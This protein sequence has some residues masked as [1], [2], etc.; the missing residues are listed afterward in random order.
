[1]S[2]LNIKQLQTDD[3]FVSCG[4]IHISK[5]DVCSLNSRIREQVLKNNAEQIS[6]V[7]E[8]EL[9]GKKIK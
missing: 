7:D 6:T 8:I 1:M 3:E 9:A 2:V 4:K 5:Q